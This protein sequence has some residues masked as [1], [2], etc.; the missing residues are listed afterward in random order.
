MLCTSLRSVLKARGAV[1]CSF[2]KYLCTSVPY[3]DCS[4]SA[5]NAIGYLA[6]F[7]LSVNRDC[8]FIRTS[9]WRIHM[10][11]GVAQEW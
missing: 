7:S 4:K 3:A 2:V 1:P 9:Y 10:L 8:A 11:W 6:L 5:Y